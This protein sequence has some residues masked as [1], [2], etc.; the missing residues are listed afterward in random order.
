MCICL[1]HHGKISSL[2][3]CQLVNAGGQLDKTKVDSGG[4]MDGMDGVIE[5]MSLCHGD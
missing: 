4:A 3:S 2:L 1:S 5:G